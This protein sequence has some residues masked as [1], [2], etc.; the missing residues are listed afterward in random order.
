MSTS[1]LF[2][3]NRPVLQRSSLTLWAAAL[4]LV[5][6]GLLAGAVLR[7]GGVEAAAC[8]LFATMAAVWL[9]VLFLQSPFSRVVEP[10]AANPISETGT[11][12]E[13]V[14]P[15][16]PA[17][18]EVA[19]S[20]DRHS[21]ELY[22]SLALDAAPED[23]SPCPEKTRARMTERVRAQRISGTTQRLRVLLIDD[24]E[25][26][27]RSTARLLEIRG[28]SVLT[29]R[30][31]SE[32][33]A[34]AER[35]PELL[36]AVTDVVLSGISGKEVVRALRQFHPRLRVVYVSGYDVASSGIHLATDGSEE[37]LPK[38]FAPTVLDRRLRALLGLGV[39]ENEL[40]SVGA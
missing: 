23:D 36:L 12:S 9:F 31:Y 17:L 28:Y 29:A 8:M 10:A 16:E 4:L 1:K 33:V 26:L 7:G 39:N 20:G 15:V 22:A 11:E 25:I 32:A 3:S 21:L 13:G 37:F 2:S 34:I 6:V 5:T 14:K 27:L 30:D 40:V 38:P 18:P 19:A 35:E 24:E